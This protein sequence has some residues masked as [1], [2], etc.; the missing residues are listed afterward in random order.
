MKRFFIILFLTIIA[1]L[2]F[3]VCYVISK[4]PPA[5][6]GVAK[7]MVD[8]TIEKTHAL[9][10]VTA[11]VFDFRGYDTLGESFVLCTAVTGVAVILRKAGKGGFENEK[12]QKN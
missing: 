10:S 1:V 4:M 8:Y 6:D 9:N 3:Y 5:Y 7:Y 2:S 11:I 12:K